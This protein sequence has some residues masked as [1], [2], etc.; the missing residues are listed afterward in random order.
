[1]GRRRPEAGLLAQAQGRVDGALTPNF[2]ARLPGNGSGRPA[3]AAW[4]RAAEN[5]AARAAAEAK[6]AAE[7]QPKPITAEAKAVQAGPNT[8]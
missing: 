5:V 6:A 1:M 2:A 7:R 3:P 4:R 8:T